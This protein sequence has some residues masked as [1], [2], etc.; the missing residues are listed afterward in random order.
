M[1][2]FTEEDRQLY[3]DL[4]A[5]EEARVRAM[6]TNSA[7]AHFLRQLGYFKAKRQFLAYPYDAV[8]EDPRHILER[9]FPGR[10][11]RTINELS[12]PTRLEQQQAVLN[13]FNYTCCG[14]GRQA[15]LGT[16]RPTHRHPFDAA[17]L[18][19]AGGSAIPRHPPHRRPGVHIPPGSGEQGY[20]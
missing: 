6:H 15:G 9:H 4:S 8:Q 2:R 20:Y 17:D 11:L 16:Q 10:A 3:F 7:K 14:E 13:L 12:K 1:P 5:A 18:H 19:S